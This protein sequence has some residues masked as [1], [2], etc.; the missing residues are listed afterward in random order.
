MMR[1]IK[2]KLCYIIA[3]I[4]TS[5]SYTQYPGAGQTNYQNLLLPYNARSA[6]M[7]G[8]AV[9]LP[10]NGLSGVLDNPAFLCEIKRQQVFVGYQI[11][12]DDVASAPI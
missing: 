7:A 8:A 3:L 10:S 1:F 9:A 12:L 6:A 5:N 4:F 2:T 11:I